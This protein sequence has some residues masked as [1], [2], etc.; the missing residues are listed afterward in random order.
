MQMSQLTFMTDLISSSLGQRV[1]AST[2]VIMCF[3][4]T[5]SGACRGE[6]RI[7]K[8]QKRF[9]VGGNLINMVTVYQNSCDF[10]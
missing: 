2:G 8:E 3:F 5:G 4:Q 9:A 6:G 1:N 7:R 10:T